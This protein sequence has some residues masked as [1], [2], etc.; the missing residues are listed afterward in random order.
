MLRMLARLFVLASAVVA[1]QAF[2]LGLGDIVVK[3]KLNQPFSATIPVLGATAGQ[4]DALTVQLAG[5]DAFNRAGIERSDYLFSLKFAV[6]A[7][8]DGARVVISSSQIV[9]E[10]FLNFIIQAHS[11]D[12]NLQREYTVLLDPP[13]LSE[14]SGNSA[15]A[16]PAAVTPAP[17]AAAPVVP[18]RSA[19]ARV[20]PAPPPAPSA[21]PASLP[22]PG[23]VVELAQDASSIPG[24]SQTVKPTGRRHPR[25]APPSQKPAAVAPAPADAVPPAAPVAESPSAAAADSGGGSYGPVAAQETFWSIATKLRPS[26]KVSMDQV[27]LAIYRANP[28]AF[29]GGSFNGLSKGHTLRVPSLSEMQETPP[30]KAEA[31]VNAWRHGTPPRDLKKNPRSEERAASRNVAAIAQSKS[32]TAISG[33]KSAEPAAG[34]APPVPA[35]APP[36]PPVERPATAAATPKPESAPPPPA[37]TPAPTAKSPSAADAPVTDKTPVDHPAAPVSTNSQANSQLPALPPKKNFAPP[38]EPDMLEDPTMRMAVVIV[39]IVLVLA[40]GWFIFRRRKPPMP[41]FSGGAPVPTLKAPTSQGPT[42]LV[43]KKAEAKAPPQPPPLPNKPA[44]GLTAE[45]FAAPDKKTPPPIPKTEPNGESKTGPVLQSGPAAPLFEPLLAG[46]AMEEGMRA[47]TA[48]RVAPTIDLAP[49]AAPAG[50]LNFDAAPRY[51][52]QPLSINLDANDPLSEADFHL[53]YGLYDEAASLLKQA[54]AKEPQ[55]QDLRIKLAETYF[56]GGKP[57]EFQETA[58]SMQGKVSTPDWQKIAI[59]GRQ[60]C[61]DSALFKS[62][63]AA[64]VPVALSVGPSPAPPAGRQDAYRNQMIDF[65]LDTELA[66][67]VPAAPAAPA[68]KPPAASNKADIDLSHFDF[69]DEPAHPAGGSEGTVE[70]TLDDLDLGKPIDSSLTSSDEIGTKFDLARVYADMGDNEAARGLLNEVLDTGNA[71]QKVEAEA[72]IKRLSV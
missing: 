71:A 36:V 39:S 7:A 67:T 53:A 49:A 66:K 8:P 46:A 54:L 64:T 29:E 63:S 23:P 22:Q 6:Q 48:P 34:T 68:G 44:S 26:P 70:F 52:A 33:G 27:L 62:E 3:S 38:P 50:N 61:P 51:E 55:R 31:A 12:G 59:M 58:E 18:A 65:D 17:V 9:H 56:A 43:S 19:P 40:L 1:S 4:L 15:Q 69:S 72:L 30:A 37:P 16:A 42:P 41:D 13:G 35:V 14:N 25:K 5:A 47:S 20:A 28:H 60:L 10:P 21:P 32:P 11:P 45:A 57:M 24:E 2:A